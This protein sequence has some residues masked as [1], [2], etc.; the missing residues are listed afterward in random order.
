MTISLGSLRD[1]FDGVIPSII[2]TLDEE[3][4]PNISYLSHVHYVDESHV[5]LSNQF[6]SKTATNVRRLGGASLVVVDGRSGQQ[7]Q[8]NIEFVRAFDSGPLFDKMH[9]H[10]SAISA[11]HG[12][13]NIMRLKSADLYRVRD[14]RRIEAATPLEAAPPPLP[15]RH[16]L[17]RIT[18]LN[19]HIAA[20]DESETMLDAALDGLHNDFG[21]GH[22]MILIAHPDSDSL[23]AIA[24]RGYAPG[25]VGAE[26]RIGEGLI[27]TVAASRQALRISDLRRARRYVSAVALA[28]EAQN[29]R[30]IPLPGLAQPLC[31]LAVPMLS[32]GQLRGVIFVESERAFAFRHED[33]DTL[34]LIAQQLASSLHLCELQEQPATTVPV[35]TAPLPREGRFRLR[36][37][38]YDGSVF[39]N[40][41]YLIKGVPGR[42][43]YGFVRAFVDDGRQ[44]FSNRE[45]RRDTALKL[46]DFKDNLETRLIL[47]R[48]RL[49][50]K[51]GPIGLE[52]PERGRIRLRLS[53]HP[54][55][56]IISEG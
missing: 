16:D 42:L 5:A 52:R 11:L 9:T 56:E 13:E 29:D 8:L 37:Y 21:F 26:V 32:Q 15:A 18:H 22:A 27:G 51:E 47:L 38:P 7:H 43:L 1:S 36:Y 34:T 4:Q 48:R 31:Q 45:I 28:T 19:T 24:Q 46:P 54:D 3:G 10:L 55:I 53:A 14:C 20:Q 33:E 44:D 17:H 39:I 50:E 6:F 41:D 30:E 12:M 2:A 25:G 40:D 35:T 23:S 49:E